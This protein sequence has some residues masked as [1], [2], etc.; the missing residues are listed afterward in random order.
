MQP[1]IF[2][3]DHAAVIIIRS[4]DL[5]LVI[6]V[7]VMHMHARLFRKQGTVTLQCFEI[8][9]CV[10]A[11]KTALEFEP[12]VELFRLDQ[13]LH[14]FEA[15]VAFADQPRNQGRVDPLDGTADN[16]LLS[17][18]HHA[19]RSCRAAGPDPVTV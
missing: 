1:A 3:N 4:D 8:L 12:S 13:R 19:A 14:I 16:Q 9:G 2:I 17:A 6:T 18:R 10:G 11:E 7:E 15:L 5:A